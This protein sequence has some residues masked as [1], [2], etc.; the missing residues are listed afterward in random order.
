MDK[1][2]QPTLDAV[3]YGQALQI[4]MMSK[5]FKGFTYDKVPITVEQ[6]LDKYKDLAIIIYRYLRAQG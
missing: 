4:A 6:E 5:G 2:N 3:I 1:G